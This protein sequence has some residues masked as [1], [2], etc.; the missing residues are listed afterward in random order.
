MCACTPRVN[1]GAPWQPAPVVGAERLRARLRPR[2]PRGGDAAD[3]AA[4]NNLCAERTSL[5]SSRRDALLGAYSCGSNRSPYPPRHSRA[6]S[7][8][9]RKCAAASSSGGGASTP[10]KRGTA[11]FAGHLRSRGRRAGLDAREKAHCVLRQCRWARAER[12]GSRSARRRMGAPPSAPRARAPAPHPT[13]PCSS[14][15]RS[16]SSAA[17]A[18]LPRLRRRRARAPAGRCSAVALVPPSAKCS[19]ERRWHPPCALRAPAPRTAAAAS[20]TKSEGSRRW[21]AFARMSASAASASPERMSRRSSRRF[22]S[23]SRSAETSG[24]RD[25]PTLLLAPPALLGRAERGCSWSSAA[26]AAASS[27][28]ARSSAVGRSYG[29]QRSGGGGRRDYCQIRAH[30][31]RWSP[32]SRGPRLRV[33]VVQRWYFTT[34]R[35]MRGA[36]RGSALTTRR[37]GGGERA[38]PHHPPAQHAA[39][40]PLGSARALP[41]ARSSPPTRGRTRRI[42]QVHRYALAGGAASARG[43]FGG[44]EAW[45]WAWARRGGGGDEGRDTHPVQCSATVKTTTRT[46]E[47]AARA[48]VP[49][50]SAEGVR[51]RRREARHSS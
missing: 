6:F 20:G 19:R 21:R 25:A 13:A 39:V 45:A 43:R 40:T 23:V 4:S 32:G 31:R 22:A 42:A 9:A 15:A 30:L 5:R 1:A 18:R 10:T 44:R 26:A 7:R 49:R 50:R 37:R 41:T 14:A 33:A 51:M 36:A 34:L 48:P 24:A 2:S 17:A 46:S 35:A 12:L 29:V 16:A 27:S 47:L 3:A 8:V 11:S 28:S 38:V